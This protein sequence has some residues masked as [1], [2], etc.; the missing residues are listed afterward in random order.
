MKKAVVAEDSEVSLYKSINGMGGFSCELSK[1]VLANKAGDE[2]SGSGSV[3][4]YGKKDGV[5]VF[6]AVGVLK[7]ANPDGAKER[8]TKV[9]EMLTN[10]VSSLQQT[11]LA[12]VKYDVWREK[13]PDETE[14]IAVYKEGEILKTE[15]VDDGC[16]L[17]YKE[18]KTGYFLIQ[19]WIQKPEV[20]SAKEFLENLRRQIGED[21][22]TFS[23]I[24]EVKGKMTYSYMTLAFSE[25]GT[26][27]T[28]K[29]YVSKDENESYWLVDLY[30]TK[31]DVEKQTENLSTL[32][33]SLQEG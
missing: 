15:T 12:D 28:E 30:G 25:N 24:G 1:I 3:F 26:D 33:W 22:V 13:L 10:C 7:T 29:V 11:K 18:D 16:M 20:T 19:H 4:V 9:Q 31:E 21:G 17:F 2:V 32:L 27:Y 6:V 14:V 8:E 23:E 5:G